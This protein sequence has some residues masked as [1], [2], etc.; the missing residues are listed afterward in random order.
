LAAGWASNGDTGS[1]VVSHSVARHSQFTGPTVVHDQ[2]V[3]PPGPPDRRKAHSCAGTVAMSNSQPAG[4]PGHTAGPYISTITVPPGWVGL[5]RVTETVVWPSADP[6]LAWTMFA[7]DRTGI[8]YPAMQDWL[9]GRVGQPVKSI[10]PA[11]AARG[12]TNVP[13]RLPEVPKLTS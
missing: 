9:P 4:I 8:G 7:S 13:C 12:A 5:S 11:T 1:R 2:D 3:S 10:D 6:V